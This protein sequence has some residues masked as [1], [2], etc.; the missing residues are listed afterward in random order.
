M[1]NPLLAQATRIPLSDEDI[2]TIL[3]GEVNVIDY[4]Q[5][6][7]FLDINE[8]LEPYNRVVIRYITQ[9]NYGHWTCV[10]R[11]GT[12][13]YVFD[14]YGC[15]PDTQLDRIPD[16]LRRKTNQSD[17]HLTRMLLQWMDNGGKVDY[18]QYKLQ[19]SNTG[20]AT[21]GDWV[22][23]RLLQ[24]SLSTN[25]FFKWVSNQS[26]RLSLTMDEFACMFILCLPN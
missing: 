13:I 21:C 5:L 8:L 24:S 17:P 19:G 1:S 16:S 10:F 11:K 3:N 20:L 7:D 22:I 26:N 12:T 18:N 2:K 9:V 4:S 15:F 14:S 23:L 6:S 25:S